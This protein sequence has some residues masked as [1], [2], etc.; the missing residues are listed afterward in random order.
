[1][2]ATFVDAQK[3]GALDN[4]SLTYGD[5]HT[6]RVNLKLVCFFTIGDMQGGDKI[7]CTSA[8]YSNTMRRMCRK[9]NVKGSGAG[10]PFIEC[11]RMSMVKII[12]LVRRKQHNI[13]T[14]VLYNFWPTNTAPYL[15]P[16]T[17]LWI[18]KVI[19]V[20]QSCKL[21]VN[22]NVATKPFELIATTETKD[23]GMIG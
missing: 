4:V 18:T 23:H 5:H 11:Q 22:T 10:D 3:E 7:T 14:K 9:C 12:D 16:T 2:F 19:P 8:S 13:F 17:M 15:P 21:P 6:K 20:I 1:V